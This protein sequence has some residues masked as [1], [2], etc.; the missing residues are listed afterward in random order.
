MK[1]LFGL[2]TTVTMVCALAIGCGE[3]K[4]TTTT[5]TDDGKKTTT[6]ETTK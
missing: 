5:T 4:K 1:K 2:L 6:T 3:K